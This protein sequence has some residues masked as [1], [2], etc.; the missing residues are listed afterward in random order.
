[1]ASLSLEAI[2]CKMLAKSYILYLMLKLV[3]S[4]FRQRSKLFFHF[5]FRCPFRSISCIPLGACHKSVGRAFVIHSPHALH[6]WLRSVHQNQ[7]LKVIC[8]VVVVYGS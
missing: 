6:C 5:M 2:Q 3:W 4:S 7:V 1:M 8:K